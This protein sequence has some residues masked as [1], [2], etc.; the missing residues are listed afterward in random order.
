MR[1]RRLICFLFIA[2]LATVLISACSRHFDH[3][4]AQLKPLENCRKIKHA[5]GET[6]VPNHPQ[7]VITVNTSLFANSFVL[8]IRPIAT[9]WDTTEMLP[10]YL[11]DKLEGVELIGEST[12]PNLEKILRLK[13]DLIL[14][15]PWSSDIYPLLAKIAPTV[16][17]SRDLSWQ[18]DLLEIANVFNKRQIG[19]VLIARYWQRIQELQKVLKVR[20]QTIRVSV[21]GIFPEFAHGYGQKSHISNIL[22]DIGLQRPSAQMKDTIYA[23]EYLSEEQI[24]SLDGDVMFFLTRDGKSGAER[25]LKQ[26]AQRPLWQQLKVIQNNRAYLV[27]YDWHLGDFLSINTI[28]DDLYRYL[29]DMPRP[30]PAAIA[31]IRTIW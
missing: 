16:I 2:I 23:P 8:G 29:I 3:S 27:N 15:N 13:P 6:C 19:E 17:P 11:R 7:R 22:R 10:T 20:P 1:L 28:V 12:T 31:K 30:V 21:A 4:P 14:G 24:S 26:I 5:M 9:A 25:V 18:Q